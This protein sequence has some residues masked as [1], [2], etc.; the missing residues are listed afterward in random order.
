MM[1]HSARIAEVEV[2][3]AHRKASPADNWK[4]KSSNTDRLGK[5]SSRKVPA[6][7]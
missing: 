7:N 5:G 2:E 6:L 4:L 3:Q 1:E